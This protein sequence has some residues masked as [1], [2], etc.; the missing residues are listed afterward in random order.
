MRDKAVGRTLAWIEG[1]AIET[2]MGNPATGALVRV[3][4][5]HMLAAYLSHDTSTNLDSQLH[6]PCVIANMVQGE[7]SRWRTMVDDDLFQ[8][9]KAIGVIYRAELVAG[10]GALGYGIEKMHTDGRFEIADVP[11]EAIDGFSTRRAEIEA[12]MTECGLGTPVVNPKLAD[13]AAPDNAGR[14]ARSRP[15]RVPPV[16]GA[17]L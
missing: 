16:L 12:A 4:N 13:R 6:T 14:Q 11:R 1:N 3:G 10:L 17:R 9:Q 2:Q 8:H 15:G 7:D 5:Q